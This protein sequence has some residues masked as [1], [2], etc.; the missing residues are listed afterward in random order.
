MGEE[1]VILRPPLQ[2]RREGEILD[3]VPEPLGLVLWQDV[4]HLRAW[5]ESSDEA[6]AGLFHPPT[7]RSRLLRREAQLSAGALGDALA[8]FGALTAAPLAAQVRRLTEGCVQ[9]A[10]WALEGGRTQTAIEYAEVAALLDPADPALANL[11]GRVTRNAG[12]LA[13]AEVWFNRAIG[14]ARMQGKPIELT[15]A[16]LGYGILCQELGRV[17][18]AMRHFNSGSRLARKEGLEWLAAEV[19]HDLALLLTVRG[20]FPLAEKHAQLALRWYGKRHERFPLFA[21]DVALMMVMERN[22]H[23]AARIARGALKHVSHPAARAVILALHARALA[24][25]GHVDELDR[26]RRRALR[27]TQEYRER[28]AVVLWHLAA[29]ERLAGRWEEAERSAAAALEIARSRRDRETA[30]LSRR[31]LAA[32][33][34]RRPAPP[35]GP[36]RRDPEFLE[37]V[38]TLTRRLSTWSPERR[39]RSPLRAAWAA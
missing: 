21:A 5:A 37:F 14:F 17:Q 6:R 34:A 31:L 13:R 25:A 11:A 12:E 33:Q 36:P 16:H 39:A 10:G 2:R 23:L 18:C 27:I 26:I 4:R 9:V 29:A 3:E 28:E 7:P 15:R 38:E 8:A 22:Y 20:R 1:R 35:P 19:Q 24:G 30:R 32:V